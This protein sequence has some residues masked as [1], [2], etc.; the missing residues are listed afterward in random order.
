MEKLNSEQK[1]QLKK[2]MK[3]WDK[4]EPNIMDGRGTM[5]AQRA[6]RKLIKHP[7]INKQASQNAKAYLSQ[8]HHRRARHTHDR[9]PY[10]EKAHL[11]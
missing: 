3:N 5:T 7:G 9:V 10:T 8:S 4:I 11:Q 2:M 1:F 6:T